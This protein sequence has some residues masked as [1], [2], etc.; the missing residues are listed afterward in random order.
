MSPLSKTH[1]FVHSPQLLFSTGWRLSLYAVTKIIATDRRRRSARPNAIPVS[2]KRPR[3]CRLTGPYPLI[4]RRIDSSRACTDL[5]PPVS[6]QHDGSMRVCELD[7]H[8][9]HGPICL[10]YLRTATQAVPGCSEGL[11]PGPNCGQ[12]NNDGVRWHRVGSLRTVSEFPAR[13]KAS[14]R[15][16]CL[17]LRV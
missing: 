11:H 1:R 6:P 12:S 15:Q 8:Q 13:V 14:R 3:L 2:A 16:P 9:L 7:V 4:H 10:G 17:L 5:I